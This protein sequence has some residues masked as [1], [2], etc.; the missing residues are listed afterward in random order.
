MEGPPLP[1]APQPVKAC[2]ALGGVR[3]SKMALVG[4]QVL[5]GESSAAGHIEG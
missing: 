2:R 3:V 5:E 1:Q 4:V